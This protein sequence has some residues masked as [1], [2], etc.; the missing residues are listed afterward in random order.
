MIRNKQKLGIQKDKTVKRDYGGHLL[1][2]YFV[3]NPLFG[4]PSRVDWSV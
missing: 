3:N 2:I 4:F 1:Q